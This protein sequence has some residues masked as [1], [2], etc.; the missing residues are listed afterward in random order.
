MEKLEQSMKT[1]SILLTRFKDNFGHFV[2]LMSYSRY[3][4]ASI[5]LDENEEIFYSFNYKGFVIEKPK[6]YFTKLRDSMAKLI[7]L[8]VT[9]EVYNKIK[10]YIEDFSEKKEALHYSPLGV[11]L[12]LLHIPFKF[13]NCYFCS[14]FI[15]EILSKSGVMK[16]KKKEYLYRPCDFLDESLYSN[17]NSPLEIITLNFGG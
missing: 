2:C 11:I 12:C 16:L 17:S 8:Q 15:S 3:S 6:K 1:I 5:S 9:V 14:Q 4:H 10:S 13:K 7:R